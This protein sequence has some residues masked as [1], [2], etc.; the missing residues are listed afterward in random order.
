MD[1]SGADFVHVVV[2]SL[3]LAFADR[4][5]YYGDF[6]NHT[7]LGAALLSKDH[8]LNR[9][10][11]ISDVEL[12]PSRIPGLEAQARLA[13]KIAAGA[14]NSARGSSEPTFGRLADTKGR[15]DTCLIAVADRFGN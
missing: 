12:R 6:A 9:C 8:A 11:Q 10:N 2:E 14:A 1:P 7:E 3:K 13:V 4:E 15:G 5:S